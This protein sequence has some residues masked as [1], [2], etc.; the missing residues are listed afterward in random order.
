LSI[1]H[2]MSHGFELRVETLR[3]WQPGAPVISAALIDETT[4]SEYFISKSALHG[5][6]SCGLIE[7][8]GYNYPREIEV[9]LSRYTLTG[10]GE[11]VAPEESLTEDDLKSIEEWALEDD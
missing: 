9:C 4:E 11:K 3:D 6:Q 10:L 8:Y 2:L 7:N 1:L 5:L